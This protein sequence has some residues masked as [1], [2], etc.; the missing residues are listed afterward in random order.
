MLTKHPV[1]F[2]FAG[3]DF[4]K[5]VFTLP[6]GPFKKRI[7]RMKNSGVGAYYHAPTPNQHKGV[8]FYLDSDGM[9][10]LRW[11][12][13]DEV[14]DVRINHTGW[15]CDE[16]QDGKLR[17]IVMRLPKGKG[18][19]AGWSMGEGMSSSVDCDII[20]NEIDAARTADS[21]A[22][23]AAERE[24]EYQDEQEEIRLKEEKEQEEKDAGLEEEERVQELA[25]LQTIAS[26]LKVFVED[27][28]FVGNPNLLQDFKRL[29]AAAGVTP[30]RE[31]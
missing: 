18:F 26:R 22:E 13:C 8:G 11:K 19:L 24:R 20:D 23:N 5:Y 9:P 30:D 28:N 4:P 2:R 15:F 10:G 12:W 27:T 7:E 6:T 14:E 25:E 21:L 16:Y 1:E 31:P 29:C 17:G 3:F